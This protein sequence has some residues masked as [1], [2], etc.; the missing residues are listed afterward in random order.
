MT[1]KTKA[2]TEETPFLTVD[3][4]K[5][6]HMVFHQTGKR[7]HIELFQGPDAERDAKIRA[8]QKSVR[9]KTMIAVFGPQATVF[10][11]PATVTAEE[12]QLDFLTTME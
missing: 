8:S 3:L 11:P 7:N 5:P 12:V 2:E 4:T 10:K 6:I 1:D 9:A